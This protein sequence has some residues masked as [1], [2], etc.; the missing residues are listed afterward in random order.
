MKDA[1]ITVDPN[2]VVIDANKS[3]ESLCGMTVKAIT[4]KA[5]SQCQTSCGQ[6]CREVLR[7]TLEKKTAVKEYRIECDHKL[8]PQQVVSV[9]SSPLIDPQG[10]FMGAVMVI[11]DVTL[12]R[13]VERELRERHQFQNLIGRNKTM[14]NIY[15]LLEDLASLDTTVLVT[16]ESGTG[17]ELVAR[18]LALQREPGVQAVYHRELFRPGGKPSGERT[19]RPCQGSVY[20]GDQ[21]QTGKICRSRRRHHPAR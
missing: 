18:A 5:L 11:R 8:R 14:Q 6:A 1:I 20:R 21:G 17:K 3:T 15:S 16:G 19:V 12:I 7:Q 4:G 10:T 9:S 2:L 13:D